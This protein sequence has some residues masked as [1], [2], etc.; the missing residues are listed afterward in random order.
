VQLAVAQ[1]QLLECGLDAVAKQE[2]IGQHHSGAAVLFQL[3]DDE[4]HEHVGRF[5]GRRSAG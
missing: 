5:A 4:G 2:A 3:L 1:Q